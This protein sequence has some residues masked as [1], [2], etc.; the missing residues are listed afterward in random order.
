MEAKGLIKSMASKSNPKLVSFTS[1][2]SNWFGQL[3]PVQLE[4]HVAKISEAFTNTVS[5]AI[6]ESGAIS[7][8]SP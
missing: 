6:W 4:I 1:E 7:V 2:L 5:I 3:I 8:P